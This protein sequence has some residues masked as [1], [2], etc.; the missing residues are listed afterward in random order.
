M[1][2]DQSSLRIRKKKETLQVKSNHPFAERRCESESWIAEFFK[3]LA[4]PLHQS[5]G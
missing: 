5:E 1:F 4:S 3:E 2:V